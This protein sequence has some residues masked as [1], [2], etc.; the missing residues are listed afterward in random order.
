[1]DHPDRRHRQPHG[2]IPREILGE[3]TTGL[4]PAS[5]S[6]KITTFDVARFHEQCRGTKSQ[7]REAACWAHLRRDFQDVW[8]S[9]KSEIAREALERIGKFYDIE[10]AISGKPAELRLT[11]RQKET[12]PKVDAFRD[13]AEKQLTRIPGKSDLAKAFRYGLSRWSALTLFLQ[14]GR[15]WPSTTMRPSVP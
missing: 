10:R 4:R 6:P 14:D 9:T 1:M 8:S 5:A 7:F 11:L 3:A 15:A 12:R 2:A 13:W